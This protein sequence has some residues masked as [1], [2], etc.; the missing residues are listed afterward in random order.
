M[1]GQ[2]KLQ[3]MNINNSKFSVTTKNKIRKKITQKGKVTTN[4]NSYM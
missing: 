3:K 4:R 2:K 1:L